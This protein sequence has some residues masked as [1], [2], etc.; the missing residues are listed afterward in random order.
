[1][2]GWRIVNVIDQGYLF[3]EIS[4][5]QTITLLLGGIVAL[6]SI[7][8][9]L[10][11]LRSLSRS[12]D[13]IVRTMKDVQGGELLAR[14]PIEAMDEISLIGEN[15][16]AMM[17]R[18]NGLIAELKLQM[19][20]AAEANDRSRK[21]EM[22]ALEAQMN[23]H[24]LYNTLDSIN[25]M[26]IEKNEHQISHMLKNLAQILRYSIQRGNSIV[27][28]AD[29][30]E[31]LNQ[32]VYL[33]KTRFSDSFDCV[34][35]ADRDLMGFRIHKLLLQTFVENSIIHGFATTRSG[36]VLTISMRLLD[37]RARVVIEDNG[38]GIDVNTLAALQA[39]STTSQPDGR[40][41]DIRGVGIRNTLARMR[42][43]YGSGASVQIQS[44]AG[45]GTRVTLDIPPIAVEN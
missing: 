42:I 23:P 35:D 28:V 33:Q 45:A 32:Y 7:F 24:F 6:L 5:F 8:V 22:I 13:G 38:S 30:I 40:S 10:S 11:V 21:A 9:I 43:C 12:I 27:T 17:R 18:V 4:R 25:W 37:T 26:A 36:G 34:I 44:R 2:T 20:L 15:F 19:A 3:G 1:L 29:E 16:N 14:V 39:M 41:G 31:W